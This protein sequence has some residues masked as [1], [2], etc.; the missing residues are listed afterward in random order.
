MDDAFLVAL[1]GA[2]A[3]RVASVWCPTAQRAKAVVDDADAFIVHA[4]VVFP[5]GSWRDVN[6]AAEGGRWVAGPRL[7]PR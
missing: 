6:R 2:D 5:D 4:R 3:R 7:G 1:Y